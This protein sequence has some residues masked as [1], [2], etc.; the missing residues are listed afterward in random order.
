MSLLFPV[1]LLGAVVFLFLAL[2]FFNILFLLNFLEHDGFVQFVLPPLL[3]QFYLLL[4]GELPFHIFLLL[5]LDVSSVGLFLLL[6]FLQTLFELAELP[7]HFF[8]LLL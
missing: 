3:F 1:L 7:V 6:F 5:L 2:Y 8:F 4:F